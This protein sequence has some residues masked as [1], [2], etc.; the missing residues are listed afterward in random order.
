[1][2]IALSEFEALGFASGFQIPTRLKCSFF[3]E[4]DEIYYL[5]LIEMRNELL[6]PKMNRV[7]GKENN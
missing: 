5:N 7:K 6:L 3:T 2:N 1:M 4:M